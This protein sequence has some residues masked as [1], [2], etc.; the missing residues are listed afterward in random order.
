M[1][2]LDLQ[3]Q[4]RGPGEEQMGGDR[5]CEGAREHHWQ[6]APGE[7]EISRV[8]LILS[9]K[10]TPLVDCL[11]TTLP[12]KRGQECG[13]SLRTNHP[14]IPKYKCDRDGTK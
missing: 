11:N 7:G 5:A 12:R 14:L 9:L 2:V 4:P 6:T 10:T 13:L 8:F 1:A 3:Q